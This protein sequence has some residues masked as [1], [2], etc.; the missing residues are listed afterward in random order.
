MFTMII[1]L[2]EYLGADL[3]IPNK[4]NEIIKKINENDYNKEITEL[5]N[6]IN[7]CLFNNQLDNNQDID[8]D[9][10]LS[11]SEP[12]VMTKE[13]LELIHNVVKSPNFYSIS[14]HNLDSIS[15]VDNIF[16]KKKCTSNTNLPNQT[17]HDFSTT[18]YDHFKLEQER[19]EQLEQERQARLEQER[20]EQLEQQRQARLEQERQEQLEQQRQARFEQE[21]L[22]KKIQEDIIKKM[23]KKKE[24]TKKLKEVFDKFKKERQ[25]ITSSDI[26]PRFQEINSTTSSYNDKFQLV[27]VVPVRRKGVRG[28]QDAQGA[29]GAQVGGKNNSE[30]SSDF[31]LT[32][33]RIL[34]KSYINIEGGSKKSREIHNQIIE[35]LKG[36]GYNEQDANDIKNFIYY[37]VKEKYSNLN[38][39]EK[40]EK[41]LEIVDK[42]KNVDIKKVRDELKLYRE[43]RDSNKEDKKEQKDKKDKKE[44]KEKKKSKRSKKI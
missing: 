40:A 12:F 18:S 39:D 41:M 37:E 44:L 29:Q 36:Y 28:V 8:T 1:K 4:K 31:E 34:D 14:L 15:S 38:N 33:K 11:S 32:G 2:L 10:H 26:E 22:E 13:P 6:N 7:K 35:I 24:E 3:T 42:F 23:I 43:R 17:L 30:T 16:N 9:Y 21:Q 5:K 27:P 25:S 19:Q 20:Q